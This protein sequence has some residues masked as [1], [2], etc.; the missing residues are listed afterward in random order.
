MT[1]VKGVNTMGKIHHLPSRA[2]DEAT[3]PLVELHERL[4]KA[5]RRHLQSQTKS[6]RRFE[7]YGREHP[8]PSI[9]Y[10]GQF[11]HAYEMPRAL[12]ENRE[13]FKRSGSPFTLLPNSSTRTGSPR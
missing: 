8:R 6:H 2:P 3:D 4:R 7:A 12:E 9:R 11:R 1:A 13:A 5:K 10:A